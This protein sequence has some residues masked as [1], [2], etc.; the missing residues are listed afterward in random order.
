MKFAAIIAALGIVLIVTMGP[1]PAS[2]QPIVIREC[3]DDYVITRYNQDGS[4]KGVWNKQLSDE[5]TIYTAGQTWKLVEGDPDR[6]VSDGGAQLQVFACDA[7]P[8]SGTRGVQQQG[9]QGAQV[10][11]VVLVGNNDKADAGQLQ[12]NRDRGQGFTTG[13]NSEGYRLT[14]VEIASNVTIAS[15][16]NWDVSIAEGGGGAGPGS[17]QVGDLSEPAGLTT[18]IG[19]S[20]TA[21]GNGIDLKPNTT[22]Y[23]LIDLGAENPNAYLKSTQDDGEN[24]NPAAGWTIEDG[25]YLRQ[26]S[27]TT[28]NWTSLGTHNLKIRV[29]GYTKVAPVVT[30][31]TVNGTSLVLTFDSNLDTTSKPAANR[32][33]ISENGGPARSATGISISGVEVRLTVPVVTGGRTVTVSYSKPSSNPLK[34]ATGADVAAFAAQNVTNNT[35]PPPAVTSAQINGATLILNFDKDLDTG[36]GTAAG[37]FTIEAGGSSHAATAISISVRQVRLTVPPVKGGQYVTVSYSKPASNPLKGSNGVDVLTLLRQPVTNNT[38]GD[39]GSGTVRAPITVTYTN[40]DGEEETVEIRAASA[41]R[42]TL[43]DYFYDSCSAARSV[44]TVHDYSQYTEIVTPSGA[45]RTVMTQARNGWKWV[46]VQNAKGEVTGTRAETVNECASHGMYLRQ[47]TCANGEWIKRNPH[48]LDS[49]CPD[50]R[51]W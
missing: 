44:T 37:R 11:S 51:T 19:N 10:T 21:S 40:A 15:V 5:G 46:W 36:S 31:A 2:A 24:S 9:A 4:V 16:A 33:T 1:A 38:P 29:N 45:T 18:G 41:D 20:F 48:L 14:S 12:F 25:S 50:N 8:G 34:G 27:S 35:P 17:T 42:D 3:G 39:T 23:V 28:T 26:T 7:T 6:F 30:G 13:S 49:W 47:Q 43:W 22:Y 32:F